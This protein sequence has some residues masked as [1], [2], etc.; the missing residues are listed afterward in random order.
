MD[1]SK[2]IERNITIG[3]IVSTEYFVKVRPILDTSLFSASLAKKVV[4]WC[5]EFYDNYGKAPGN[6]MEQIYTQKLKEENIDNETALD[7]EDVLES[8][9]KDFDREQFNVDYLAKQTESYLNEQQIKQLNEKSRVL[10]ER[11][12]VEEAKQ[13]QAAFKPLS[14]KNTADDIDLSDADNVNELIEKMFEAQEK[15][16]FTYPGAYGQMIN[17][18]LI[19]GGFLAFF[20]PEKRGKTFNFLDIGMRASKEGCNVVL[21]QAGDMTGLQQLKRIAINRTRKSDKEKYTGKQW[22]ACKD[23]IFN[24]MDTCHKI[25]RESSFGLFEKNEVQDPRKEVTKEL[26]IEKAK[27]F[28]DY[29]PCHNCHEYKEKRWGVPWLE[30]KDLGDPMTKEDAKKAINKF[31]AVKN[32]RLKIASYPNRTLT[33]KEIKRRLDEWEK[34]GFFVDVV[35]VD[36]ADIMTGATHEYRHLQNEIWMDLRGLSQERDCL[37]ITATQTDANSYKQDT[38]TLDNFSEDKRK[39]AH[40]TGA[41]G[42]NQDHK[43]REK[44]IGILR[45]NELVLRESEM[46]VGRQV[47]LIQSLKQ[48]QPFLTSYF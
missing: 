29:K 11:G 28:P 19:R 36:Y 43:G 8:M 40:V 38:I 45:V 9:A 7:I 15:P 3:L 35:V 46:E 4:A 26:L 1:T 48:G 17:E 23:C 18:H 6:N 27:E 39:Y 10:L 22:I 34:E 21:F 32:R 31:F 20:A 47:T 30:L 42:L 37:V 13:L 5:L 2:F 14:L 16:L 41:F 24:Q 12:E 44:S 33:V 25:E